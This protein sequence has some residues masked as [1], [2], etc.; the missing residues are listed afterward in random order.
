[1]MIKIASHTKKELPS[2]SIHTP[3][4]YVRGS[5]S[6]ADMGKEPHSDTYDDDEECIIAQVWK[7]RKAAIKA[8]KAVKD[9]E[10]MTLR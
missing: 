4:Q 7:K 6:H 1:M 3:T 8:V 5:N 2:T 9:K 10:I